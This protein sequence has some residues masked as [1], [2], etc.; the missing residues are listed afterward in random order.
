MRLFNSLDGTSSISYS[1][2][3]NLIQ[4]IIN[5]AV[6]GKDWTRLHLLFLGGGGEQQHKKGSGGLA[7]GCDASGVPLDEVI[8]CDFP[9]LKTFI[10]TLLEHKADVSPPK[11]SGKDPVDVAIEL[12]KFDLI[13]LLM[14]RNNDPGADV[15]ASASK[16]FQVNN[17]SLISKA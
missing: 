17:H 9:D 4:T 1:L 14:D 15:K 16:C 10:S 11:G 2:P 6:A 3:N 8:R 13:S 7:T 5:Q 12:E